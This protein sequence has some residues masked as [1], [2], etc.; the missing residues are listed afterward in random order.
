[1]WQ[2]AGDGRETQ[3]RPTVVVTRIIAGT[4]RATENNDEEG[5]KGGLY[6]ERAVTLRSCVENIKITTSG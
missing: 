1:M 5:D 4:P 6:T 2:N 3:A